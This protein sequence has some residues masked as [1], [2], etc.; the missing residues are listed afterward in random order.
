MEDLPFLDLRP[1]YAELREEMDAA[2]RRVADS[3]WYALGAELEEFE[4]EFAR[5]CGTE[6]CVGVGCGLDSLVFILRA[7]GLGPGDEVIVPAHTFIATWIAVSAVG[8]RPVPVEPDERTFNLDPAAVQ[9]A[10]GPRTA[11]IMPVHLYGQPADL[12]AIAAIAARHHLPV[13]EDASQAHGARYRGRRV[14]ALSVAAGF[15]LNPVK[16]LGALGSAGAVVTSDAALA[17]KIRLLRNYGMRIKYQH[18]LPGA[19]SLLDDLQAAFLRVKLSRLDEW[20]SRRR[21]LAARYTRELAGV[22]DLRLPEVPDWA[23]P[24][25]HQFVIRHPDRAAVQRHLE[26]A[27]IGT[28]IHYPVPIHQTPVYRDAGWRPGE[29]PLAERLAAEILSLPMNP[30]LS[31]PAAASVVREVRAAC[32]SQLVRSE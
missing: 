11:A 5:Y 22:E 18:E 13:I 7:L 15:S 9:A 31:D 26:A 1:G 23:E 4:A 17:G 16:N 10:I 12:D 19:N 2:Y 3:G 25:W 29:F 30:H 32:R 6:H 21:A 8:A 20:N 27:G 28:L 14:G 24:V